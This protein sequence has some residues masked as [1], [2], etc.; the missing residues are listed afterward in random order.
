MIEQYYDRVWEQKLLLPQYATLRSRW[1]SR[2]TFASGHITPESHILDAACG[3]GVFGEMLVRDL[4]CQV[5]GLDVSDRAR[6]RAA[7]KGLEV[8]PCDISKDRFP[9]AESSVE[10][11]TML[12]CLEHIFD[13][14]HAL[15]EA[16]RVLKPNGK[17]LVTLPNAVQAQFRWAFLRGRLSKDLLH[18]NDGEGLHIRFFDYSRD[19]SS[20]VESEAPMLTLV[21]T[22]AALK[23][24]LAGGPI[25]RWFLEQGMRW[26]PNLFAEYSHHVLVASQDYEI[27]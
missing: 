22:R 2:W 1:R 24:P 16:A 20:L 9:L 25:R 6:Q 21:E 8:H 23:N 11:V 7:E 27:G 10:A 18:T 13:P 17:V 14:G 5:V 15:R 3:D 26:W 19:F 4:G 12:C